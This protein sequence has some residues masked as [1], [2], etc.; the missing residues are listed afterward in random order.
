VHSCGRLYIVSS[1]S[2][3]VLGENFVLAVAVYV[4]ARSRAT[5][6]FCVPEV[7]LAPG[8][9]AVERPVL[10]HRQDTLPPHQ[11]PAMIERMLTD[12]GAFPV[13]PDL[14]LLVL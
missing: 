3:R 9:R 6:E 10:Y 2:L 8:G 11:H 7:I 14:S 13:R 5:R 1:T 4:G 12:P